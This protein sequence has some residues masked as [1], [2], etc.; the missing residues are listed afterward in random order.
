MSHDNDFR[1]L[2][3]LKC[4]CGHVSSSFIFL[5]LTHQNTAK[6]IHNSC[7]VQKTIAIWSCSA[8]TGYWITIWITFTEKKRKIAIEL[9]D[10]IRNATNNYGQTGSIHILH[11]HLNK[12]FRW[13]CL[14]SGLWYFRCLIKLLPA[15]VHRNV[16]LPLFRLQ[17]QNANNMKTLI[18]VVSSI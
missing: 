17:F 5:F 13:I 6:Y 9:F 4:W 16:A 1:F 15:I 12:G 3:N 10:F 11:L 2:G 18:R 7:V 14:Q 8:Y